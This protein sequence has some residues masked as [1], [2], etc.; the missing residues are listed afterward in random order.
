MG[1]RTCGSPDLWVVGLVG[2]RTCGSSDLWDDTVGVIEAL[3]LMIH[4]SCS[5]VNGESR[6]FVGDFGIFDS[7]DSHSHF[8]SHDFKIEYNNVN[9]ARPQLNSKNQTWLYSAHS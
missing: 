5:F 6:L 3:R 1:R 4:I 2:L 7:H 8:H 9:K